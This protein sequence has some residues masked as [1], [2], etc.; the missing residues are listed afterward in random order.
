MKK[1]KIEENTVM[2]MTT[3]IIGMLLKRTRMT[4][5]NPESN[6]RVIFKGGLL[7]RKC[8]DTY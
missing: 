5:T 3:N 7:N 2:I 8:F 6:I 1:T 4:R